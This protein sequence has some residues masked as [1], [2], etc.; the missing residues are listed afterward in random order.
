MKSSLLV[1]LCVLLLS[2]VVSLVQGCGYTI[3]MVGFV[4]YQ[5]L[6]MNPPGPRT[7]SDFKVSTSPEAFRVPEN[8][9]GYSG[10]AANGLNGG[11]QRLAGSRGRPGVLLPDKVET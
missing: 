11:S 6:K 7:A 1:V 5:Y 4:F 2:E 8:E 10:R 3:A 9:S